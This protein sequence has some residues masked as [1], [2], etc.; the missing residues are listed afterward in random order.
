MSQNPRKPTE[1][2][3]PAFYE[4]AVPIILAIIALIVIALLF[5]AV[6]VILGWFPVSR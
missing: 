2:R 1:R 5:I 3:Y 4:R 6:A